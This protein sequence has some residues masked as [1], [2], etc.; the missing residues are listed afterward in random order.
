MTR[1]IEDT[2]QPQVEMIDPAEWWERVQ[3]ETSKDL[4]EFINDELYR[5]ERMLSMYIREN[6]TL[7][8]RIAELEAG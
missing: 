6:R 7:K 5:V 4:W 1:P 2:R 8:K 3:E